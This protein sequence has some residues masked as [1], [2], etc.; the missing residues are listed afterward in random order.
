MQRTSPRWRDALHAFRW[1]LR[2][3]SAR[4]ARIATRSCGRV[5]DKSAFVCATASLQPISLGFTCNADT[6][7][8]LELPTLNP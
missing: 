3:P 1:D 6:L 2:M 7:P 5:K 8:E 4:I